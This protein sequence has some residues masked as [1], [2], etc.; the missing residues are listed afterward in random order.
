MQHPS[1][2]SR[3]TLCVVGVSLFFLLAAGCSLSSDHRDT[4]PRGDMVNLVYYTIGEPDP[5][6][7]MVNDQINEVLAKKIGITLTYVKIGW[8]EYEN[9]LNTMVSAGTP[10]DIAYAPE[11]TTYVKRG[12]WL[13]LD[14]Y[15]SSTGKDMYDVID[16]IFWEGV[17]MDDGGIYGVPTNKELAV[18][19]QWMYPEELVNKYNIDTTQYKT[20]ESLEPLFRMIQQK[21][22][23]YLPMEL[24]KD[25][26]NFFALYGYEYVIDKELPLMLKSLD[27]NSRVVDIFETLEA[28]RVLDTLRRYYQA[29]YINE[30]AALRESQQ[31]ERGKKVFWKASSGGPLSEHS[32]SKDR[33][34]PV[35]AQPVTTEVVTTEDVRGGV[36][37]VS[38]DTKYPVECIKFLNLLN[39]DPEVRNLFN[40]GI[41]GVHYTLDKNDQIVLIPR[42]DA[43]GNPIPGAL[44]GYTGVTYTQGNWFILKTR[45]GED[46]EPLNKWEEFRA[47]NARAV[48]SSTFGFT[49]DLSMM[50]IQLQN[51]KMVWQK[52][53]PSLMTGSVDVDT[54]LPKFNAE[55]KQAGLDEVRAEVQKQLD[56]WRASS[57]R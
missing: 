47:S 8:Q 26:H 2:F 34:Y 27:A 33:G 29:G 20:L 25:S 49:P 4:V 30:D 17:R 6:L 23:D 39:T 41:E 48:K 45:G 55:L 5:D 38:A 19:Q 52:Y 46:P 12:A 28:R 35:V 21:E 36:M 7:E 31:L 57:K 14:D 53:Y 56:A 50:P 42:K 51:I 11:F 3:L 10:F 15:L 13:R 37:A 24:D 44:P 22:P 43:D 1:W 40:Y 18:R 9:R 16:P 32:W 54:E